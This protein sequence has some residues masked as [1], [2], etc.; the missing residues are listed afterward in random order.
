MTSL[1]TPK[2][3]LKLVPVPKSVLYAG[4]AGE[5]L[6]NAGMKDNGQITA[7]QQAV[8]EGLVEKVIVAGMHGD[9]RVEK[10]TLALKPFTSTDSVSLQVENGKS[11]FETLDVGLAAAVQFTAD[12]IARQGLTPRFFVDWSARAKASPA[13]IADAI[14]RLN[15]KVEAETKPAPVAAYEPLSWVPPV[16]AAPSAP[17]RYPQTVHTYTAPPPLPPN[18][19]YKPVLSITPPADSGVTYTYETSRRI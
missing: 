17:K 19:V 8:S 11:F 2:V 12:L 13:L 14:K 5:L 15:L 4:L 18:Y 9:G 3:A 16:P 7:V 1:A 6:K 10:F